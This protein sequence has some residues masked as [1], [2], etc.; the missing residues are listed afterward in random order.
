MTQTPETAPASLPEHVT[1]S[2]DEVTCILSWKGA[3]DALIQAQAAAQAVLD[4]GQRPHTK[5]EMD[6]ARLEATRSGRGAVIMIQEWHEDE[7][8]RAGNVLH[9]CRSATDDDCRNFL[10]YDL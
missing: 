2:L 9:V 8:S 4:L 10:T 1:L 5:A 7:I 3:H 6:A